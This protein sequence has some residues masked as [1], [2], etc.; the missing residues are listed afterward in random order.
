MLIVDDEDTVCRLLQRTAEAAGY[1]TVT[2]AN[3]QEALEKI[4]QYSVGIIILDIKMPGMSGIELLKTIT[5]DYP[6]IC[7]VMASAVIDTRTA[8]ETMR[9]GADDYITK[10]FGQDDVIRALKRAVEKRDHRLENERHRQHLEE[11][12]SEQAERLQQQFVDLVETLAREHKL[13]YELATKQHGG[14]NSLFH[15]LPPELRKPM[16]SVEEYSE[17]LLNILKRTR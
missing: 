9:L 3:G 15:K 2:A 4:A 17:A 12:I 16:T 11:T 13:L 1:T 14:V 8:V 6:D 10:P 5:A 7:V